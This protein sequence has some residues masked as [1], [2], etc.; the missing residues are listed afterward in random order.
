MALLGEVISDQRQQKMKENKDANRI[1]EVEVLK[2]N[3]TSKFVNF[4]GRLAKF[5]KRRERETNV[6]KMQEVEGEWK[7]MGE[8]SGADSANRTDN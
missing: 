4:I 6:N 7:A 3:E 5:Q 8:I 1:T 2:I